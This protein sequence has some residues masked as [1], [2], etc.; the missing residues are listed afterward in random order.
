M[1]VEKQIAKWYNVNSGDHGST[2]V[3]PQKNKEDDN[4]KPGYKKLLTA[5][6]AAVM[7]TGCGKVENTDDIGGDISSAP[8]TAESVTTTVQTANTETSATSVVTTEE[9]TTTT[10]TSETITEAQTTSEQSPHG[11]TMGN[12]VLR[13]SVDNITTT[14]TVTTTTTAPKTTTTA[15][16]TTTT[17]QTDAP[18]ETP[19]DD[20]PD[21]QYTANGYKIE[22]IDGVT[23]VDGI[24]I[25]NKSYSV[26]SSYGS[27]LDKE[28]QQAFYEM[29]S[30][31]SK[32]GIRLTIV[33]GYRSYWYQDQ[34]Y[35]G[36]VYNRG[37]SE[38]DRFSARAGHSEHQTGLSMD[39]NN[40]SRSFVGTKEAAWIEEHCA[41]YGF[42]V[43][44]P[45]G[46]EDVTGFM[47]EPWH[48]RYLGKELA[49]TITD[50]GLTLEEY[51]GID[52]YYH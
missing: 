24:L 44:Y 51:L 25:V 5:C 48:V 38:A 15:Q 20:P 4:M 23:Y 37:Q 6:L 46:K 31:A 16:T 35:R 13:Q 28:A 33:S 8:D 22:V 40:A 19:S 17:A 1:T 7:L 39:L 14:T 3:C 50:S 34:L 27:G 26:P 32:D 21:E 29:Q 43:R 12:E 42:I 41:E 49:K 30:A 10:V 47:Y 36:Y 11:Q 52:S 2:P 45:D 9:A 18:T